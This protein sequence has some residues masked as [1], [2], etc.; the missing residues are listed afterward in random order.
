M[1]NYLPKYNIKKKSSSDLLQ[2]FFLFLSNSCLFSGPVYS[3]RRI[4][5]SLH[6]LGTLVKMDACFYIPQH[7]WFSL[8]IFTS[9][10]GIH[11]AYISA[12]LWDE[13]LQR[14]KAESLT[15]SKLFI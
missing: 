6:K 10:L 8:L 15:H 4:E 11:T 7:W 5:V 9:P 1:P 13:H 14:S 12:H 2:A 3:L